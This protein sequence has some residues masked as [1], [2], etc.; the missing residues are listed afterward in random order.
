MGE[1]KLYQFSIE[2]HKVTRSQSS[3]Q[4]SVAKIF[5]SKF[6]IVF[7][8]SFSDINLKWCP[9]SKMIV[10]FINLF[11]GVTFIYSLNIPVMFSSARKLKGQALPVWKLKFSSARLDGGQWL[12][13]KWANWLGSYGFLLYH[14][15]FNL[16]IP[17]KRLE[18]WCPILGSSDL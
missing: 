18:V 4:P 13:K 6:S 10:F 17:T 2:I 11:V 15:P 5:R 8:F 7:F 1:L 9:T 12:E 3:R 16:T 14:G